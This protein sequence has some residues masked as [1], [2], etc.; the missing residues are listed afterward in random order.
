VIKLAKEERLDQLLPARKGPPNLSLQ[1][2]SWEL[3]GLRKFA[4]SGLLAWISHIPAL[5]LLALHKELVSCEVISISFESHAATKASTK[6]AVLNR[7]IV[8][9]FRGESLFFFAPFGDRQSLHSAVF[10]D[11]PLETAAL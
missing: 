10:M 9:C 2:L 1:G 7:E 4:P 11:L 8:K 3:E 5:A 6:G